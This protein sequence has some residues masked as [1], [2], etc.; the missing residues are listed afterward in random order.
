[1]ASDPPCVILLLGIGID[2]LS[3]PAPGIPRSEW[4]IRTFAR[5]QTRRLLGKALKLEDADDIRGLLEATPQKN[6]RWTPSRFTNLSLITYFKYRYWV[7]F[8]SSSSKFSYHHRHF[9]IRLLGVTG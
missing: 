9:H 1:M 5:R 3:M 7:N 4:V 6:T 2:A 8:S